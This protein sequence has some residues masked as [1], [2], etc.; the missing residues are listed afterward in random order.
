MSSQVFRKLLFHGQERP[1]IFGDQYVALCLVPILLNGAQIRRTGWKI[2]YAQSALLSGIFPYHVGSVLGG[3]VH[4]D[5][6]LAKV[7]FEILQ[8]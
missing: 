1:I 5:A 2:N 3:L 6:R 4:Y 8:I 7:V